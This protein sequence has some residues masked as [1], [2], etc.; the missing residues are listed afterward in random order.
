MDRINTAALDPLPMYATRELVLILLREEKDVP[1]RKVWE[2]S[3]SYRQ[4]LI[5]VWLTY[6]TCTHKLI[7]PS[8]PPPILPTACRTE[9]SSPK[10]GAC[11]WHRYTHYGYSCLHEVIGLSFPQNALPAMPAMS[12]P[13]EV[14]CTSSALVVQMSSALAVEARSSRGRLDHPPSL[15]SPFFSSTIALPQ[16]QTQC[17]YVVFCSYR[18]VDVSSHVLVKD[19]TPTTLV[20]ACST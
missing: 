6:L 13:E 4:K 20:T 18:P 8:S 7:L 16:L 11:Q 15:P 19:Y 3:E 9:A 1:K 17:E 14:A 12:W 5:K 2:F 10:E